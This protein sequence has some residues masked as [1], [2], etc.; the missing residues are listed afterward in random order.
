MCSNSFEDSTEGVVIRS[1]DLVADLYEAN[2]CP[3]RVGTGMY[4]REDNSD[5]YV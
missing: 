4:D 3:L 2:R 5:L 1:D